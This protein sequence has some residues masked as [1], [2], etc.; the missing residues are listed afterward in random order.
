VRVGLDQLAA[1]SPNIEVENVHD[2]HYLFVKQPERTAHRIESFIRS[3]VQRS[4][5]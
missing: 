1:E 3:A 4:A 2:T 5:S